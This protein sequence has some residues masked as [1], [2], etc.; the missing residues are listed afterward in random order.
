[1]DTLDFGSRQ[2]EDIVIE[3]SRYYKDILKTK[4][5]HLHLMDLVYNLQKG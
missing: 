4:I 2:Y 5:H 1:M 3:V